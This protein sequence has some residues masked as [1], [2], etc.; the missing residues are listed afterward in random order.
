MLGRTFISLITL[1]TIVA[2]IEAVLN[3]CPLTYILTDLNDPEPPCPSHLL[4]GRKIMA[5]PY[6]HVSDISDPDYTPYTAP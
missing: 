6:P 4:Y 1:Q 3:D 5:L 2:E